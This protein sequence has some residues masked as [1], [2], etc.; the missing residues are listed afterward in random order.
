MV[1]TLT[2]PSEPAWRTLTSEHELNWV[3]YARGTVK[4]R[5]IGAGFCQKEIQVYLR[6]CVRV[7]Y[8][9]IMCVYIYIYLFIYILCIYIYILCVCAY[10]TRTCINVLHTHTH[11]HTHTYIYIYIHIYYYKYGCVLQLIINTLL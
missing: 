6:M 7:V 11:T 5:S 9:L 1:R 3:H 10:T 2:L 4:T 8:A